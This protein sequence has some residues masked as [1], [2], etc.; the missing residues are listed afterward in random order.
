MRGIADLDSALESAR[1][2]EARG[3]EALFHALG[4]SV[5]A[6][7]RARSVSDA[8]DLANEVFLRAFRTLDTFRGDGERFKSW[9][10]TIAHHA[11]IDDKRRRTR[12]VAEVPLP[13]R[14]GDATGDPGGDVENEALAALAGDRIRALLDQLSPDQR[15]VLLLRVVGDLSAEQTAEALDKTYEAVKALQRRG[16]AALR[17]LMPAPDLEPEPENR[18]QGVPR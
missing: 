2:G 5:A 13:E 10:F 3:Y 16:L 4:G 1:A 12:R 7:L 17:R 8:D 9:L 6:Y 15:D 18:S 11:A 14:N